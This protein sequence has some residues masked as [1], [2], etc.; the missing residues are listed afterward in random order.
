MT[1]LDA[2]TNRS[3]EAACYVLLRRLAPALKHDMVGAFQPISLMAALLQ[4]RL[5][6]PLPDMLLLKENSISLKTLSRES[7]ACCLDV[8][9]WLQPLGNERVDLAKGIQESLQFVIAELTER[10]F[11]IVNDTCSIERDV[12]K[13]VLRNVFLASVMALTDRALSTANVLLTVHE[14]KDALVLKISLT[15]QRGEKPHESYQVY[16][17]MEWSDVQSLAEAEGVGL[18]HTDDSV[19]I[20]FRDKNSQQT[21]A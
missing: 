9:S 10:G 2:L 13:S 15:E 11:Q 12:A 16:R 19:A 8:M 20:T 4:K 7:A 18:Q 1:T 5:Q 3:A 17:A 14:V 21:M 6:A